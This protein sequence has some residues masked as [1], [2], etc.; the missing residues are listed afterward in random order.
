MHLLRKRP[1][2]ML[3]MPEADVRSGCYGRNG[4]EG[5]AADDALLAEAAGQ[6]DDDP[7]LTGGSS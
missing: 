6:P 7:I 2:A 4:H 1:V 3:A 5:A